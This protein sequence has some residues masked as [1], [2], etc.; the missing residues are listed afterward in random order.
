MELAITLMSFTIVIMAL[1][2]YY[3]SIDIDEI[4][5]E[6][7]KI[8]SGQNPENTTTPYQNYERCTCGTEYDYDGIPSK[9]SC[10]KHNIN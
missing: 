7:K 6:L 3:Q 9:K 8:N 2:I 1:V 10:K 4:K 5:K